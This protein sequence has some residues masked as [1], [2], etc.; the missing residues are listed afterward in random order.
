[1]RCSDR[2]NGIQYK[3]VAPGCMSVIVEYCASNS[4]DP[5]CAKYIS[6]KIKLQKIEKFKRTKLQSSDMPSKKGLSMSLDFP[7]SSLQDDVNIVISE[8]DNTDVGGTIPPEYRSTAIGNIINLMPHGQIF[9]TCVTLEVP[10]EYT[11]SHLNLRM[12]TLLS[13][14]FPIQF[15]KTLEMDWR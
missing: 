12:L 4:A 1:M 3:K 15:M 2:I 9:D 6:K 5:G 13:M 11:G 14:S 8:L 7:A 10:Y